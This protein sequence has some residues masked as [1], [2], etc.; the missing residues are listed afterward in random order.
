[1]IAHYTKNLQQYAEDFAKTK[2]I[3]VATGCSFVYGSAAFDLELIKNF[4]PKYSGGSAWSFDHYN[5]IEKNQILKQFPSVTLQDN[6]SFNFNNMFLENSFLTQ[7][8]QKHLKGI[9]TP[10]NLGVIGSG[11][12]ASV[13]R[14]LITPIPWNEAKEII[15]IFMPT[16]ME[17]LCNIND[18]FLLGNEFKTAWPREMNHESSSFNQLQ[19]GFE[20]TIYSEKWG[21][22]NFLFSWVILKQ[23]AANLPVKIITFPAFSSEY[24]KSYIEKLLSTRIVRNIKTKEI[25][26]IIENYPLTEQEQFL[27]DQVDWNCFVTLQGK[28]NFFQLAFSQEEDYDEKLTTVTISG[29][30]GGSKNK[31]IMNCGHPGSLAHKLLADELYKNL[32]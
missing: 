32:S 9:Y 15:L 22:L 7:L 8:H 28:P 6:G 26:D 11:L 5:S 30:N 20:K 25:Q 29:E 16:S 19:R 23:W 10:I 24:T 13:M 2:K 1:M 27:L 12:H 21:A 31:W 17:R 3:I 18:D 4:P 14:L